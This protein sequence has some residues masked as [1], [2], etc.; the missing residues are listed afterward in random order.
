MNKYPRPKYLPP[1]KVWRDG[2]V[3]EAPA[4]IILASGTGS[5]A[6]NDSPTA[7]PLGSGRRLNYR[8]ASDLQPKPVE[9]LWNLRIPRGELTDIEGDP[10]VNKSSF[11][12][13]LAACTSSG[14]A[15]PG[16]SKVRPTG[17]VTL[18][19]EDSMEKTVIQRLDAAR[20]DRSRIAVLDESMTIPKDLKA[21]EEAICKVR[22]T[23][24]VIDPLMAHLGR[25]ANSDQKVRQAL[26]PLKQLAE[27]TNISVV[28]VRHLNKR[29]G[30]QAMYRGGGS[31][32]ITAAMRSS[33]LIARCPHEPNLRVLAQIKSNLGPLAPSLL[34]EPVTGPDGV[35][36]IEWRGECDYNPD[37]LLAPSEMNNGRLAEAM[38]FLTQLLKD[39][40]VEQKKIKLEAIKLGMALRTLERAK[41]LLDVVSERKGFGPGSVCSWRWPAEEAS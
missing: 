17:V 4:P 34:F 11:A 7:S 28:M 35:V 8:L 29:G 5:A 41:E 26:T 36:Q 22:A 30:R 20:A 3:E 16:G 31:I 33:L 2:R 15:L 40:P 27:R 14:R 37:D 21:M 1:D 24:F 9:W 25:D 38:A 12:I 19:S 23:L 32:G 13:H 6:I 18:V 10:G 39:G